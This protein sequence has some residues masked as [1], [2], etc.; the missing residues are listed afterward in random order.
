MVWTLELGWSLVW[1]S[2]VDSGTGDNPRPQPRPP[3]DRAVQAAEQRTAWAC[4]MT[5]LAA[6][7]SNASPAAC[8]QSASVGCG[9]VGCAGARPTCVKDAELGRGEG[10]G[11]I[12]ES[13][14]ST[15]ID[16]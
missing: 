5:E 13:N 4:L 2:I 14:V 7:P 9:G 10:W 11:A 16:T 3:C 12:E 1:P 15:R 6:S 8:M